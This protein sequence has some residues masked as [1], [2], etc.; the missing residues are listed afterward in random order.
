MSSAKLYSVPELSA[1]SAIRVSIVTIGN[2]RGAIVAIDFMMEYTRPLQFT[3]GQRKIMSL[4]ASN[5]S[6]LG[7]TVVLG[8]SSSAVGVEHLRTLHGSEGRPCLPQVLP[9]TPRE[10]CWNARYEIEKFLGHGAQGY[11]YLAKREGVDGYFTRVA[12][13]FFYHNEA[14]TLKEHRQEMRRVALQSQRV[15]RVQHDSLI[16]IR[17]FVARE[18]ETRVMVLEWVDGIDLERLL[19]S[20]RLRRLRQHL[21]P[22]EWEHL[23]DVIVTAGEDHCRL[24]PGIAVDILRGCLAGLGALHKSDIVHCDLKPSNIMVKQNGTKKIIDIDSSCVPNE[25]TKHFRG[26]PYYMA[27]EQLRE[28]DLQAY[29][30]VAS[31]GYILLEMLTGQRLFRECRSRAD[32]IEAKA[33]L[34][35][36]LEGILPDEIRKSSTLRGLV[37]RMIAADPRDRFQNADAAELDHFGTVSFQNQLVK[38]DLS[39]EYSRELSWWLGLPNDPDSVG[40]EG[41]A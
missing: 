38:M 6:L 36:R 13:K 3:A 30:D 1:A 11:V 17:D 10:L 25:D 14:F 21:T 2:S 34:P 22:K 35:D 20:D 39:T 40:P 7:S 29:S 4:A 18:D 37:H 12:L 26:T 23:N 9:R 24:K 31:L 5:S 33:R 27:P 16:S 32:L 19:D 28:V 41:T 8:S 15:S